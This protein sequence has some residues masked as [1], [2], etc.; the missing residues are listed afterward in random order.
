M[1]VKKNEKRS[2]FG[3]YVD[4]KVWLSFDHPVDGKMYIP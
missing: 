2:K 1:P 4:K 3:E